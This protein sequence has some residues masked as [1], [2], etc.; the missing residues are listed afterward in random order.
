[1]KKFVLILSAFIGLFC[2]TAL[3]AAEKPSI[4]VMRFTNNAR[5]YWWS[6]NTGAEMQDMLVNELASTKAFRIME[7]RE[8]KSAIS[9]QQLSESGMMESGSK[10][11]LGKLKG[12]RY[13][14]FATVSAFEENTESSG[15]GVHYR[16]FS[17]GGDKKRAYIAVD[18]KV[19]D[20]ET[21]EIIDTR[22]VEARSESGGMKLS[23][24]SGLVPGLSGGLSKQEK[25][26]VGKAIRGCI[27]EITDYLECSMTSAEN[28]DCRQKY[29]GKES[30]RRDRTKSS[31]QLDD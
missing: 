5:A 4:A 11:K 7:R 6:N 23:G 12:A 3:Y 22:T 28:D 31:V 24:P 13:Q 18:L 10:V 27:V 16:G 25:T 26:P 29:S 1:M 15:G 19:I 8:L 21:G 20:A 9:E 17:F 2:S 30:R 14:I